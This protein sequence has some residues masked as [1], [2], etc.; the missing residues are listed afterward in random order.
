M[1]RFTKEIIG[2]ITIILG[3][4]AQQI[5]HASLVIVVAVNQ[6]QGNWAYIGLSEAQL[7]NN[8]AD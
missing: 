2:I 4:K 5:P 8:S 1:P 6:M 3:L 7:L